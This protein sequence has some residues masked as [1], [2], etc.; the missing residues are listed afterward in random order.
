MGRIA[1]AG[2]RGLLGDQA[3]NPI[4]VLPLDV[5]ELPVE[6]L[7]RVRKP[8]ISVCALAVED[9]TAG[10]DNHRGRESAPPPAH[11]DHLRLQT[12]QTCPRAR[13]TPRNRD[14]RFRCLPL[15]QAFVLSGRIRTVEHM[16]LMDSPPHH[17][18]DESGLREVPTAQVEQEIC[19]LAAHINAA[20]ARWLT[21]VGE[22]DRRGAQEE[23]GFVS[24]ASWLAWRCS[25]TPRA[26]REQLRVARALDE[27]PE[28]AAAFRSGALSYSKARALT[29]AATPEMEGELLE[30]AR[31]ATAAQLERILSGYRR[32]LDPESAASAANR[33]HVAT[34]WE[35]D[36]SLSIRANLPPEEG[37]LLLKALD[38]ARESVWKSRRAAE[39]ED[40]NGS[41][42]APQAPDR[43]D[44]LVA[45]AESAVAQGVGTA[46]GGER[47][48]VVV[49]VEVDAL[50]ARDPAT[51]SIEDG[52]TLPAETAR[53]LGC[54]A[55][56]LTLVERDGE[57]LSVGRKTRSVPPSLAR[58]L[59]SRDGGCRFPGCDRN[60]FVD[61]H[62]IEHW[63]HGG[64]T[65]L[66]NLVQLCRHHHRLVHEGG[67]T[68]ERTP[69]GLE[70]RTPKG[71]SL[72]TLPPAMRGSA[73]RCLA[74]AGLKPG[75]VDA[76]TV[77]PGSWGE[78]VDYDLATFVLADLADRRAPRSGGSD[79]AGQPSE[80]H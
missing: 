41:A 47:S 62:H 63:A 23:S 65:S 74:V 28:I 66:D 9:A 69:T 13:W 1:G 34:R 71:H 76:G 64:E 21:L 58:A 51:A 12:R 25:I 43:A 54:D 73:G 49:H 75:E 67:F 26:A 53:R 35:E 31:E 36:G 17:D 70:F 14:A 3:L 15:R 42:S 52:P 72:R 6:G 32:A 24:C 57:P 61:A 56:I 4:A 48:Q 78:P 2:G 20:T 55:S 45:L 40:A 50:R 80:R 30:L 29:R 16:F 7:D 19:E 18:G 68:I 11:L 22:Y 60:H 5:V 10:D 33:R 44:A 39:I 77:A 59:R 8:P 37:A 46:S 38:I 27:L 79:N